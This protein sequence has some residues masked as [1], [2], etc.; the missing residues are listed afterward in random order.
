V[1]AASTSSASSP[2][3]TAV[4]HIT[5]V[6]V[7]F[8]QCK[9]FAAPHAETRLLLLLLWCFVQVLLVGRSLRAMQ[10]AQTGTKGQVPS[11]AVEMSKAT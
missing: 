4:G 9:N 10:P 6:V 1:K 5:K 11:S 7:I 3:A 2:S 8:V